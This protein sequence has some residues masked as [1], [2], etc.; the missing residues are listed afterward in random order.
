MLRKHLFHMEVNEGGGWCCLLY[1]AQGK[2]GVVW[3]WPEGAPGREG[4]SGDATSDHWAHW[5]FP[6]FSTSV[7]CVQSRHLFSEKGALEMMEREGR[8]SWK[9]GCGDAFS[10]HGSISKREDG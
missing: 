9:W 6:H 3:R 2:P 8:E 1:E 7:P 5:D 4:S 10:P